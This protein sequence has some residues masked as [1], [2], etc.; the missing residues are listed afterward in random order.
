[1][2]DKALNN[3]DNQGEYGGFDNG[4]GY[5]YSVLFP[6]LAG[7]QA[8]QP[9]DNRTSGDVDNPHVTEVSCGAPGKDVGQDAPDL[10]QVHQNESEQNRS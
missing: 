8:N 4:Y 3:Q 7:C 2:P 10:T 9:C 6:I 5:G 1:M